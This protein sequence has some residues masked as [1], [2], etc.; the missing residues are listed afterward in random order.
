MDYAI[1]HI[2][3]GKIIHKYKIRANL[4]ILFRIFNPCI[5]LLYFTHMYYDTGSCCLG[6]ERLQKMLTKNC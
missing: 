1:N 6:P 2:M 5:V 4:H 3:L